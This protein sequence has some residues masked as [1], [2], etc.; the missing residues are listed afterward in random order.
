MPSLISR[1]I[2]STI[3]VPHIAAVAISCLLLPLQS[4]AAPIFSAEGFG[5]SADEIERLRE[6]G[7]V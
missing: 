5:Y 7:V 6:E 1:C 4:F 3:R 2:C